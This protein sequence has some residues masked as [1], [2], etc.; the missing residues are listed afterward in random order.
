M[1][2]KL[3]AEEP[4]SPVPV[5]ANAAAT[6]LHFGMDLESSIPTGKT[7]DASDLEH[8]TLQ[9]NDP[10][11]FPTGSLAPDE[12]Y[13][14]E[15]TGRRVWNVF[16]RQQNSYADSG[17]STSNHGFYLRAR[18]FGYLLLG[19]GL[20]ARADANSAQSAA[21]LVRLG[22]ALSK[23]FIRQSQLEAARITLQRVTEL[24]PPS[25]SGA[26]AAGGDGQP[27]SHADYANYYTLRIAL[28][29]KEDRLDLAE[30]MYTKAMPHASYIDTGT[31]TMLIQLL[32]QI[33]K[34]FIAQSNFSAAA[35]W[36]RRA[37]MDLRAAADGA[38]GKTA[39]DD[40]ELLTHEQARLTAHRGLLTCLTGLRSRES[41]DEASRILAAA[42]AAFGERRI[43]IL[44][45]VMMLQA[46]KG[47]VGDSVTNLLEALLP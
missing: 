45:M 35:P 26:T 9:A 2:A 30:H 38:Q 16:L 37:A 10:S 43:E 20:L 36:F 12:A 28:S 25:P 24:L 33:G 4:S 11:K 27:S 29:W 31:L 47:N 41:L 19:I 13:Q 3:C 42:E 32:T 21:Y 17:A 5:A 15:S 1:D 8:Y 44:E 34:S 40:T 18:L 7:I 23:S 39:A 14:L 46:A 6:L 22:L